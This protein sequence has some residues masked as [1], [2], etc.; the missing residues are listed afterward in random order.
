MPYASNKCPLTSSSF[1]TC[2]LKLFRQGAWSATGH[3]FAFAK[4]YFC[5]I[6]DI[7]DSLHDAETIFQEKGLHLCQL[8]IPSGFFFKYE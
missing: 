3:F 2:S 7:C 6:V 8:L 5:S 4:K 1:L